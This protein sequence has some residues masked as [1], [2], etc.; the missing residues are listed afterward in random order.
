MFDLL[1]MIAIY[2]PIA[3]GLAW[4]LL[5]RHQ[6]YEGASGNATILILGAVG[7]SVW[8]KSV[9]TV[10][11]NL[12]MLTAL[13]LVAYLNIFLFPKLSSENQGSLS[14]GNSL[15]S[16]GLLGHQAWFQFG[17]IWQPYLSNESLFMTI[18][19]AIYS[20]ATILFLLYT[21]YL[22]ISARNST[23]LATVE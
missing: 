17:N 2:I 11:Q 21:L 18:F 22:F 12:P 5:M 15:V 6:G 23:S 8:G 3:I 16:L 14:Q 1:Q 10:S 20:F 7:L 9:G 13:L 4:W 19:L